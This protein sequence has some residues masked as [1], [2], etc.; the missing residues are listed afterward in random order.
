MSPRPPEPESPYEPCRPFIRSRHEGTFFHIFGD[1]HRHGSPLGRK[2]PADEPSQQSSSH[3]D[4]GR[5]RRPRPSV[6]SCQAN[7]SEWRYPCL[8]PGCLGQQRPQRVSQSPARFAEFGLVR[9]SGTSPRE[10]LIMSLGME[11]DHEP[12][13]RDLSTV[14]PRRSTRIRTH[15]VSSHRRERAA[16]GRPHGEAPAY[17]LYV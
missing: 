13:R 15:A 2:H 4:G 9:V 10:G 17:G 7:P 6:A 12:L 1:R 11:P 8:L 16:E 14:A 3:P 5:G